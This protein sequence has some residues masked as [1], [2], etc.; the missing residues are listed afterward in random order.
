MSATLNKLSASRE[1]FDIRL[2]FGTI[3]GNTSTVTANPGCIVH[4][5]EI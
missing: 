3:T 1:L 4:A 5:F 2:M